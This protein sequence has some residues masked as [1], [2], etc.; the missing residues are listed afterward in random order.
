L[1]QATTHGR[2]LGGS[3]GPSFEAWPWA[4]E[5]QVRHKQ[6]RGGHQGHVS[7]FP[8]EANFRGH[9]RRTMPGASTTG[10]ASARWP[11]HAVAELGH[12]EAQPGGSVPRRPTAPLPGRA[13]PRAAMARR[14][15]SPGATLHLTSGS[16][17]LAPQQPAYPQIPRLPPHNPACIS[18]GSRRQQGTRC[19]GG[20]HQPN[21]LSV[22]PGLGEAVVALSQ[23]LLRARW[24]C[25]NLHRSLSPEHV[26]HQEET[27]ASLSAYSAGSRRGPEAFSVQRSVGASPV[28]SLDGAASVAAEAE[29]AA[30]LAGNAK[31]FLNSPTSSV[32]LGESGLTPSSA[33]WQAL[34][35][36]RLLEVTVRG[37]FKCNADVMEAKEAG[38]DAVSDSASL[39]DGFGADPPG[40]PPQ[41]SRAVTLE[42]YGGGVRRLLGPKTSSVEE[43]EHRSRMGFGKHEVGAEP[44]GRSS[45]PAVR[46]SCSAPP[47]PGMGADEGV[48]L[49]DLAKGVNH[50]IRQILE[51]SLCGEPSR[52][53][54]CEPIDERGLS[55]SP[56]QLLQQVR[57]PTFNSLCASPS[58]Q[59]GYEELLTL[60]LS[61]RLCWSRCGSSSAVLQLT[62]DHSTECLEAH[63]GCCCRPSPEE[64]EVRL[65]AHFARHSLLRL[66]VARPPVRVSL[67]PL[68]GAKDS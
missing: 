35:N 5:Q 10:S 2:C 52:S 38:G 50:H 13:S 15:G 19:I 21:R 23:G 32:G 39:A 30:D 11:R 34:T 63:G 8:P 67:E 31:H 62:L 65:L 33:A 54:S 37:T 4:A 29:G 49:R 25:E 43:V 17:S 48:D 26:G 68:V 6:W 40:A 27:D 45:V 44:S 22:P 59:R 61:L 20:K 42:A 55:P 57:C 7:G 66:S 36:P 14:V 28:V 53:A 3:D 16:G 46:G 18:S 41:A 24:H 1:A 56:V 58:L 12:L 64:A 51:R 60:N 47:L 9:P